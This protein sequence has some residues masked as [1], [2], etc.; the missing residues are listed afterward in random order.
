M[1]YIIAII[2]SIPIATIIDNITNKKLDK[3][4][5]ENIKEIEEKIEYNKYLQRELKKLESKGE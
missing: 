3:I 2:L 4:K 1:I 5:Q